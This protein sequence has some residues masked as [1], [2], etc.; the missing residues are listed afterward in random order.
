M[1][2]GG[3]NKDG[4]PGGNYR[5][6]SDYHFSRVHG[7]IEST[8]MIREGDR[9]LCWDPQQGSYSTFAREMGRPHCPVEDDVDVIS[10]LGSASLVTPEANIV[11]PP[12]GPYL[13]SRA[14]TFDATSS[15]ERGRAQSGD[16]P[17]DACLCLRVTQGNTVTTYLV[18]KALNPSA[19]P[20]AMESFAVFAINLP[21]SFGDVTQVDLLHT[22]GVM[23][24]GVK[25]GAKVLYSWKLT[26]SAPKTEAVVAMYPPGREPGRPESRTAS[27]G[28]PKKGSRLSPLQ[29]AGRKARQISADCHATLNRALA[30]TLVKLSSANALKPMTLRL[31]LSEKLLVLGAAEDDGILTFKAMGSGQEMKTA[32]DKLSPADRMNLAILVAKLKPES[33]DAQ[34]MAGVYLELSGNLSQ[35]GTCYQKAGPESLAKFDRLFEQADPPRATP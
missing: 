21:A 4:G 1:G 27:R 16:Y 6:F 10:I 33:R 17:N 7:C 29:P 31:S 24:H 18:N 19:N 30:Q 32:M 34:A 25:A 11:Y 13:G 28:G 5:F 26:P 23:S 9:Y 3:D 12:I 20:A 15:S 2:G 14:A 35:A 8:Q 22:P